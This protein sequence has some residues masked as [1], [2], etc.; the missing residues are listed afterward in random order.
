MRKNKYENI[1][2]SPLCIG[3]GLFLILVVIALY[4]YLLYDEIIWAYIGRIWEENG[5]APY[6]NA[7]ENKT[8]GIYFLNAL[9]SFLFHGNALSIRLFGAVCI[10]GTSYLLYL[11]GKL[12]DSKLCGVLCM[13]I[14]GLMISWH[15]MDGLALSYTEVFMSLFTVASFYIIFKY[16]NISA[17]IYYLLLAGIF[18]GSSIVFKQIAILSLIALI[19]IVFLIN[20][21]QSFKSRFLDIGTL[22]LGA[23]IINIICYLV[24]YLNGV[25]VRE[26]LEGA[27]SILFNQ[28]SGQGFNELRFSRFFDVFFT[29]RFLCIYP[30]IFLFWIDR[31][32][33]NRELLML[34][35]VW[36]FFDFLGANL[37]GNYYGH[38]LKQMLPV[39]SILLALVFCRLK[40]R[41]NHIKKLKGLHSFKFMILVVIYF[42][43]YY[44]IAKIGKSFLDYPNAPY[45]DMQGWIENNSSK[46]DNIFLLG[47][48]ISL[49]HA[50]YESNRV[51]S[52]KFFNLMFVKSFKEQRVIMDDLLNRPPLFILKLKENS[53]VV[54]IYGNTIYAYFV[55]NYYLEKV[56]GNV[57]IYKKKVVQ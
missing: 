21:E 54:S 41:L 55:E 47:G 46:R 27:W 45:V 31:K 26:Y 15:V 5:L 18:I 2:F 20:K 9:N 11:L 3:T 57:E 1:L 35:L 56:T 13:C 53:E 7:V 32:L 38:Q 4:P 10:I 36:L 6:K 8:P 51:S 23:F 22:I 42:F 40:V 28:G 48:D 16:K 37:S 43:P 39:L 14:Y 34:L 19:V 29:T 44:Q 12:L 25:S 33:Y 24:L 17:N 50:L 30:F 52:S 49:M